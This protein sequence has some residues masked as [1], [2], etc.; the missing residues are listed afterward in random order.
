MP[1]GGSRVPHS[2]PRSP[3]SRIKQERDVNGRIFH[4]VALPSKISAATLS[5]VSLT[6]GQRSVLGPE[7]SRHRPA[8][9]NMERS[10]VLIRVEQ[11]RTGRPPP[12]VAAA[13]PQTG[14][15][16]QVVQLH[17]VQE[18]VSHPHPELEVQVHHLLPG[19]GN[20]LVSASGPGVGMSV[21]L[22]N[23]KPKQTIWP[24]QEGQPHKGPQ[25][26]VTTE[27]E[28]T[29]SDLNCWSLGCSPKAFGEIPLCHQELSL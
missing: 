4:Q 28:I 21:K 29:L 5:Q 3:P 11:E 1:S 15:G 23:I 25:H 6:V 18:E 9:G 17:R 16:A 27:M 10:P 19:P 13:G 22:R 2:P 20:T 12:G 14:E 8:G 7:L 24:H 26:I